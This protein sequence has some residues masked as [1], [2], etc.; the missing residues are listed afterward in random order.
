MDRT[1]DKNA[2]R[3]DDQMKHEDAALLQGAPDEG[4]TEPR[5]AEAPGPGEGGVGVR[6]EAEEPYHGAPTESEIMGRAALAS[7]FRPTIF[8]ARREQ[9]ID[10]ASSNGADDTLMT[11]LEQIPDRMYETVRD[12]WDEITTA[13]GGRS[14]RR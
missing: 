1:S 9:L 10:E 3:R 4:R 5:R 11:L 2:P 12:V 14:G 7:T 6:P 13:S 8:P